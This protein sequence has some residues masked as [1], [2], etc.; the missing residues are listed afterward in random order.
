MTTSYG[1]YKTGFGEVAIAADDKGVTALS[2][3][4]GKCPLA[5]AQDWVEQQT[6]ILQRAAVELNEYLEGIRRD[7]QVPLNPAGTEFQRSVWAQLRQIPYGQTWNYAQLAE[8]IG[9][10]RA[11][12]AVARANG[13]NP[14]AVMI[15]C[16]RVIGSDGSLTGYAGGLELKAKLLGL[17]GAAFISQP[18][19]L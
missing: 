8:A 19:L 11:V 7:F 18:E 10:P 6:P 3:Q 2:F 17:E 5:P 9:N 15:P 12:R 4:A 14:V 13:A 1:I 16:H